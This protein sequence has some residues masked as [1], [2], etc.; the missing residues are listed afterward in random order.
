MNTDL[1]LEVDGITINPKLFAFPGMSLSSARVSM[2]KHAFSFH[3][4]ASVIASLMSGEYDAWVKESRRDDEI[5]GGPQDLL[6][7][8]NYPPIA[9]LLTD[10]KLTNLVFGSYLVEELF[11]PMVWDKS[12]EIKYWLD[13]MASCNIHGEN[14]EFKGIC[15]SQPDT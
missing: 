7:E 2:L 12:S 15:Y 4:K 6:A 11:G 5:C 1:R 14:V 9:T 3:I 13:E 8:S 10:P